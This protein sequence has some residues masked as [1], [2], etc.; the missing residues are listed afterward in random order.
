MMLWRESTRRKFGLCADGLV[1][2]AQLLMK[3]YNLTGI[4]M[5]S[6]ISPDNMYV[7]RILDTDWLLIPS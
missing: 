4:F 3:K 2:T 6:D 1:Q 5:A 7:E